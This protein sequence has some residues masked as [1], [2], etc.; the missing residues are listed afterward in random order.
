MLCSFVILIIYNVFGLW[1]D[2]VCCVKRGGVCF[3]VGGNLW[4]LMV[5]IY[6]VGGVGDVRVVKIK[7]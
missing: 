3:I 6:N 1:Y 4:F 2:R 7:G 5:L